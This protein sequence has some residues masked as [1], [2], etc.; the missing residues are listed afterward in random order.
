MVVACS[1]CLRNSPSPQLHK[2]VAQLKVMKPTASLR[3]RQHSFVFFPK[4][5]GTALI[6]LEK[7]PKSCCYVVWWELQISKEKYQQ[8]CQIPSW[9][10][11][12]L[13]DKVWTC[14]CGAD[15]HAFFLISNFPANSYICSIMSYC[16][17]SITSSWT[18]HFDSGFLC[19]QKYQINLSVCTC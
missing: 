1:Q 8:A 12:V 17:L 5:L 10:E 16:F 18:Q 19:V 2:V 6:Q 14:Q 3:S 4:V 9:F 13:V 15:T 11:N 7:E